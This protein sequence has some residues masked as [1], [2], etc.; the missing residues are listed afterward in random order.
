MEDD[1]K[2]VVLTSPTSFIAEVML[3]LLGL[4][5]L[6]VI[7][8]YF[9]YFPSLSLL[10]AILGLF[11]GLSA[12]LICLLGIYTLLYHDY[13]HL[14]LFTTFL[15]LFLALQLTWIIYLYFF[16]QNLL[17]TIEQEGSVIA[18]DVCFGFSISALI[19]I[20]FHLKQK[21][22]TIEMVKL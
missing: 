9:A 17:L 11:V 18:L 1:R 15:S 6:S 20:G 13:Y 3:V 10:C 19:A 4:S 12:V 7:G 2:R 21:G 16:A 5:G 14:K 8:V 22:S